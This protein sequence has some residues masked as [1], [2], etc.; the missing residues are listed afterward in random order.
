[1]KLQGEEKEREKGKRGKGG[2][3]IVQT[4]LRVELFKSH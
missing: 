1:M 4:T 2:R 3:E